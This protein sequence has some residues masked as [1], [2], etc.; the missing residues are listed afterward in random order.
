MTVP[1]LSRGTGLEAVQGS[2]ATHQALERVAAA[3]ALEKAPAQV[4]MENWEQALIPTI[5]WAQGAG[6]IHAAYEE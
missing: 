5:N 6:V 4:L 1:S 2:A 3:C